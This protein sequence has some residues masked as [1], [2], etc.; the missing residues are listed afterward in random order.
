[1]A[2][3]KAK[4]RD[5]L[6][7]IM[8][9]IEENVKIVMFTQENECQQCQITRGLLEEVAA[10]SE[11]VSL[12]V[13][14]FEADAE[15]AKKLGVDKIPASLIMGDR[16]YG[17]RFYGVPAGYE[18][19]VLIQDILDVGKRS[20]GLDDKTKEVLTTIKK[21]VHLQVFISPT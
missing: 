12:E 18:F 20:P 3:I 19:N 5:K 14:D 4:D 10:L 9:I 11:K 17:I 8:K 7:D 6:I 13:R 1:M 2:L 21:P 15:L 16:D